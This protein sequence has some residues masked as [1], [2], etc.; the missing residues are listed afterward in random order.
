M[1]KDRTYTTHTHHVRQKW[2]HSTA[3]TGFYYSRLLKK[4][5]G[6]RRQKL[7]QFSSCCKKFKREKFPIS[8]L[9]KQFCKAF[10][11]YKF[12][13]K[14]KLRGQ[15]SQKDTKWRCRR[16][17]DYHNHWHH[18]LLQGEKKSNFSIL[19][20]RSIARVSVCSHTPK[21][22][23]ETGYIIDKKRTKKATYM[24]RG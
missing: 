5:R 16:G 20:S 18:I 10:Q 24:M 15:Y 11:F 23:G 19:L 7:L 1:I 17:G 22:K 8:N 9:C 2:T 21:E 13:R 6:G 14:K 4:K 12:K 3:Q